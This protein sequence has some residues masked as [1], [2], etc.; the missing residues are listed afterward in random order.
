M[1]VGEELIQ[2]DE[3]DDVTTEPS[4]KRVKNEDVS[5]KVDEVI[6]KLDGCR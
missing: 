6:K 3:D 5:V 1:T 4:S 2:L